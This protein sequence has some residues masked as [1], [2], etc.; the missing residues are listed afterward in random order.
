M[1]ETYPAIAKESKSQNAEIH[2]GDE[3]GVRNDCQHG[4]VRWTPKIGP[5]VK[6]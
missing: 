4:R 1:E 5:A 6:R 3:T 2:W